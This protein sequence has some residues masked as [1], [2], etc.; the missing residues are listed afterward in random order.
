M[1]STVDKIVSQYHVQIV[2]R[3][4]HFR[5]QIFKNKALTLALCSKHM[6]KM[7]G[8]GSKYLFIIVN[9]FSNLEIIFDST[10]EVVN[11]VFTKIFKR[12]ETAPLS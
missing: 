2:L 6:L 3:K 1:L 12:T 11:N 10:N 7:L 4:A 9:I 5:I 8:I